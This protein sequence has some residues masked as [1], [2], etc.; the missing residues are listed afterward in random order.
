MLYASFLRSSHVGH[1]VLSDENCAHQQC[2]V[3]KKKYV[4][5]AH[6]ICQ[7]TE[8]WSKIAAMFSVKHLV[9]LVVNYTWSMT[10]H[11]AIWNADVEICDRTECDT[12]VPI[13]R[14]TLSCFCVPM[15]SGGNDHG[16]KSYEPRVLFYVCK[17]NWLKG[18]LFKILMWK[19]ITWVKNLL[20]HEIFVLRMW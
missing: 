5:F 18:N 13:F 19:C 6:S 1:V 10:L 16:D 17:K 20:R 9:I 2:E 14:L 3:N 11:L 4:N 7:V 12:F 15:I 8:M